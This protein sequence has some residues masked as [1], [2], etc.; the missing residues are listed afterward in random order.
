M[1]LL[2]MFGTITGDLPWVWLL[3][4]DLIEEQCR[5]HEQRHLVLFRWNMLVLPDDLEDIH[6]FL[7]LRILVPH[8]EEALISSENCCR[9]IIVLSRSIYSEGHVEPAT[10][11]TAPTTAS[12]LM[13][14]EQLLVV[15]VQDLEIWDT[16]PVLLFDG[17]DELLLRDGVCAH[18]LETATLT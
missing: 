12:R 18:C 6:L 14:M 17:T 15:A 5:H 2:L 10:V 11:H 8:F 9:G 4:E 16:I 3:K 13:Q 1:L 7:V